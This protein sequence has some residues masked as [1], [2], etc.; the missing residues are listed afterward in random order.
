M[1]VIYNLEETVKYMDI[2]IGSL[3]DFLNEIKRIQA[4]LKVDEGNIT[5]P[6]Y[7]RG[8]NKVFDELK[9]SIGRLGC[10]LLDYENDMISEFKR[11]KPNEFISLKNDFDMIAKMQHYGLKTRLLD[12]T[13]NPLIALFFA[14]QDSNDDNGEVFIIYPDIVHNSTDDMTIM[15]SSFYNLGAVFPRQIDDLIYQLEKSLL[16]RGV[17]REGYQNEEIE[18]YYKQII[19]NNNEPICVLPSIESEREARQKAAFLLFPNMI[20][21]DN[22][23]PHNNQF[24][25]EIINYKK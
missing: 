21:E 17:R 23:F 13:E 20:N 18:F 1:Y 7:Y 19:S 11:L 10:S 2:I 15:F 8:Q 22:K 14:C 25:S 12:I 5:R 9:P 3:N 6:F 4:S 16:L 24:E